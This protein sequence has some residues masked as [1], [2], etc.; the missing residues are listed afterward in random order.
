M[1]VNVTRGAEAAQLNFTACPE[2]EHPAEGGEPQQPPA[3]GGEQQPAADDGRQDRVALGDEPA[4][5]GS[6]LAFGSRGRL[7]AYAV[8]N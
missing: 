1:I 8:A 3:D 6:Q 4:A 7:D 2:Q 5:S